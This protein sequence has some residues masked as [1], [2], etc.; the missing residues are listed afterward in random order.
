MNDE[1]LRRL[2]P[3]RR[4]AEAHLTDSL[5][6]ASP[7]VK[8]VGAYILLSGGKR[9]RPILFLLAARLCGRDEPSDGALS[10]T[11]ELLH[12]ATL[13]HD[14]VIDHAQT[15]RGRPAANRRWDNQTVVLVGDYLFAKSLTLAAETGQ[16]RIVTALSACIARLAEGQVL[17]LSHLHDLETPFEVYLEI[18]TAKT[19]V[20]L[21]AASQV[22][23]IVAGA[24][25]VQEEALHLFG[26]ELGVAFQIID[27]ILDWAGN[28]SILGKP[29]GQD[30]REGK[31]TLPWIEALKQA[32]PEVRRSM[33]KM[34]RAPDMSPD[35]WAWLRRQVENWGGFAAA[36]AR[37]E[38]Y[39][40]RAKK[41]LDVFAP[42]PTRQLL[43]DVSDYVC[44]RRF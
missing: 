35:D 21:A 10:A 16:P 11:F 26:L 19:A 22:G 1:F 4:R 32:P 31:A 36:Q 27:D 39:K 9:L 20:L 25:L 29:V 2:A 43:L 24:P 18:I 8:E 40:E 14:D 37:A 7:L 13:L 12:C 30:L 6:N 28:E 15:R 17:E 42:S 23:A 41:R 3:H 38:S 34:A 44:R 33:L 5:N